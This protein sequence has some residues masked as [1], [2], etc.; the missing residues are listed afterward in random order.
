MQVNALR[1]A[2][3]FVRLSVLILGCWLPTFPVSAEPLPPAC[4]AYG[5]AA[6]TTSLGTVGIDYYVTNTYQVSDCGLTVTAIWLYAGD[7]D[8]FNIGKRPVA[9][10]SPM[11]SARI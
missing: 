7:S 2:R 9:P 10:C 6:A 4:A 8:T 1:A 3:S 11:K 5:N